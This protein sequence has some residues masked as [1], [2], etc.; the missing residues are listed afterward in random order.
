[1]PK[2]RGDPWRETILHRFAGGSD[3]AIP[4]GGV[5]LGAGG[6]LYGA[7]SYGGGCPSDTRGCGTI[8]KLSRPMHPGG[9][10]R[11]TILH[12][13]ENGADGK[14]PDGAL[15]RDSAGHVY[16]TALNAIFQITP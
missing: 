4:A 3:G 15:V 11:E 12:R 6:A 9:K 13:F 1:P 2:R 5:M 7:T 16:G 10:W 8:F 14:N